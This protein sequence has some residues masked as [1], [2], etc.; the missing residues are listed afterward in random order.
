MATTKISIQF[1]SLS[2]LWRFR[3][4]IKVNVFSV[5]AEKCIITF[6]HDMSVQIGRAI[7]QYNGQIV[8]SMEKA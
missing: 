1:A 2:Y 6:E 3:E 8:Q 7:E 5:N 4:E